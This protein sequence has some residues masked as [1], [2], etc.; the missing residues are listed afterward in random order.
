MTF[1][2]WATSEE[3]GARRDFVMRG[4]F[5]LQCNGRSPERSRLEADPDS[6]TCTGCTDRMKARVSIWFRM[7][8]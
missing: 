1:D 2:E 8:R 3:S 7:M 4:E 5:A 6:S